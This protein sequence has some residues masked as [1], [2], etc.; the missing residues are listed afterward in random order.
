[1]AATSFLGLSNIPVL[2][3][4]N[5]NG[6]V[7]IGTFTPSVR[8]EVSGGSI[9]SSNLAV[10][11][12]N[13]AQESLDITG[14]IKLTRQI[15]AA[16]N[17]L[18]SNPTYSFTNDANTGLYAPLQD[19]VA[20]ATGGIERLRVDALGRVG[21]STQAPQAPL[22]VAGPTICRSN[23]TIFGGLN[24]CKFRG[25]LTPQPTYALSSSANYD[26]RTIASY[27]GTGTTVVDLSGN[28]NT[29][30][31]NAAP[32][33]SVGPTSVGLASNVSAISS[34]VTIDTTNGYSME[35]MFQMT[36]N[37]GNFFKLFSYTVGND[38][39]GIQIQMTSDN[40][41]Y[42]MNTEGGLRY[43]ST[44][45]NLGQWYHYVGT[46]T[47]T[48]YVNGLAIGTTGGVL[49]SLPTASRVIAVGD[50]VRT[51]SIIGNVALAKLYNY[52][53]TASNVTSLYNEA[54][55]WGGNYGLP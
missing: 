25:F 36:S 28:N 53:L 12:S 40:K 24:I 42:L 10:G 50:Q 54:K 11:S 35:I 29:L 52:A 41:L 4:Q 3:M 30:T 2:H 5:M 38:N 43:T 18:P 34:P 44:F 45:F 7:G 49:L 55:T 14:N 32:T 19:T 27:N 33:Y 16:S 48:M 26:F 6:N 47:G 37:P 51:R 46:S 8:F 31:F 13:A 20:L 1:M 22:D 9:I 17:S 15:L 39:N 23:V 21:I